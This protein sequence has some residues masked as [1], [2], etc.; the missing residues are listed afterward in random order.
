[1]SQFTL[2]SIMK[3]HKPDFHGAMEADQARDLFS[4]YVDMLKKKYS[5]E[6][7]QTGKFQALMEVGSIN[8]GP[9][10]ITY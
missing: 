6:R 8:N 1:M 2:Y 9:V 10:T 4:L 7:I 3:G 5:P